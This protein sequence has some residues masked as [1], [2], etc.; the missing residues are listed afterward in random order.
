MS[1]SR[2]CRT[3]CPAG[4]AWCVSLLDAKSAFNLLTS[5]PLSVCNADRSGEAGAADGG[6]GRQ[7]LHEPSLRWTHSKGSMMVESR[8]R[9]LQRKKHRCVC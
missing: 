5:S 9:K 1:S 7:W 2:P 8:P 6:K 4:I 3:L